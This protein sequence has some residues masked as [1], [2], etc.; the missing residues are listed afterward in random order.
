[1]QK[2]RGQL[3]LFVIIGIVIII[4]IAGFYFISQKPLNASP[5]NEK[6]ITLRENTLDCL[7]SF[8]QNS[9]LLVGFQ[10]GYSNVTDGIYNG[11]AF[12][13]YY[14]KQ[15][16]LDVPSIKTI[17]N[18]IANYI[19]T[20]IP[21]CLDSNQIAINS[22]NLSQNTTENSLSNYKASYKQHKTIVEIRNGEVTFTSDIDLKIEDGE[23]NSYII[24]LKDYPEKIESDIFSMHEIANYIATSL[25]EDDEKMC[26]TCIYDMADENDFTID[27]M[28]YL[29]PNDELIVISNNITSSPIVFQFLN[30]YSEVE[31]DTEGLF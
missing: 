14:Y 16:T 2:K 1:M 4:A 19:D 17:E 18:E 10:G 5:D 23:G 8:Y 3:T 6:V 31:N 12:I 25:Q 13:P 20:I 15:G 11:F 26:L 7:S 22:A 30:K 27:I 28:G 21:F 29:N 24:K 9:L